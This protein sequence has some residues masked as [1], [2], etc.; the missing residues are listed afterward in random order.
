MQDVRASVVALR[1]RERIARNVAAALLLIG[2]FAGTLVWQSDDTWPFAQMRMFPGGSESAV[3]ITVIEATLRDGRI[4]EMD[5]FAFHLK[6]AEIEGQLNRV[7]GNP[8]MLG[9]LVRTYNRTVP[10]TREIVSLALIRR[11]TVREDGRTR[12]VERELVRW[13]R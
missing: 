6:R 5:P 4:R 1:G 9:D 2:L 11:E 7:R 13:P 10:H 3:A 12:R 8:Q